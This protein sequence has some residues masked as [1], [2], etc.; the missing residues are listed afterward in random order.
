MI[1]VYVCVVSG[2]F[3][4]LFLFT[5]N[6]TGAYISVDIRVKLGFRLQFLNIYVR[7]SIKVSFMVSCGLRFVLYLGTSPVVRL[8]KNI[9]SAIIMNLRLV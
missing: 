1:F 5:L 9:C 4:F 3:R 6:E 2:N 8:R 7:I